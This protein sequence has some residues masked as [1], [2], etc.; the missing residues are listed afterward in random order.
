[1][2][3]WR[4]IQAGKPSQS[5]PVHAALSHRAARGRWRAR[6][7]DPAG[8]GSG[9]APPGLPRGWKP[10]TSGGRAI[11]PPSGGAQRSGRGDCRIGP[12]GRCCGTDRVA[13]MVAVRPAPGADTPGVPGVV[14]QAASVRAGL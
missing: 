1:M 6:G 12:L 4:D 8:A 10:S 3:K 9:G 2:E 11:Q 13:A 14:W 5:R 7:A